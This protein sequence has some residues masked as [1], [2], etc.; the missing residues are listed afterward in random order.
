MASNRVIDLER[1]TIDLAV[2]YCPDARVAPREPSGPFGERAASRSPGRRWKPTARRR[3][4]GGALFDYDDPTLP[5]FQWAHWYNASGGPRP[6]PGRVL[7]FTQYEQAIHAR[8]PATGWRWGA[9][10]WWRSFLASGQLVAAT[11]RRPLPIDYGYWLVSRSR[12][13]GRNAGKVRS[14]ILSRASEETRE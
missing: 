9:S 10:R 6:R 14:W 11:R 7:R 8:L 4:E 12:P 3:T 1:E 13:L 5:L 2:R